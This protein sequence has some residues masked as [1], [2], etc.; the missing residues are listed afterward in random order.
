MTTTRILGIDPGLRSMGWGVI[1]RSGST[2][3]Y[4][5]SG[6][7]EPP[8]TGAMGDRLLALAGGLEDVVGRH[9]PDC[10]SL[11]ET[12]VN[13][14]PRSAL[15]LGQARGV[16]LMVLANAHLEVG[17][18]APAVIKKAVVGTGRADKRQVQAMVAR[19]LPGSREASPDAADALAIAICHASHTATTTRLSA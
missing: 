3:R 11:E 12:Y 2:L 13:S 17:E 7:V 8:Q 5:A 9:A 10:A 1:L 19:L 16:C 18:Y 4:V 15:A 6:T 14:G